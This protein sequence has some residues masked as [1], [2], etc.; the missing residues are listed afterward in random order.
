MAKVITKLCNL[1]SVLMILACIGIVAALMLPR[2]AGYQVYAVMSGSMEPYYHVGS[3]VYVDTEVLPE[4]IQAGDPITFKKSDSMVAT[5]RVVEVDQEKRQFVTKGD[6]NT[7]QDM[8]PVSFD[9]LVGK[10]GMS[11]P[12]IGY[13]SL[14]MTT[15]KGIIVI[16]A[17]VVI[18]ILLQLIPEILK[19][20]EPEGKEGVSD[21]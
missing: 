18:F 6:A 17:V 13:I 10:A 1:I 5:H 2:L 3:I 8:A 16:A 9:S 15:R 19:P 4:E 11:I 7:V 20:E 12:Y 21:E 14:N